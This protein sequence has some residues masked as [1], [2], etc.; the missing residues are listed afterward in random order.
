MEFNCYDVLEV[1]GSRYII[2]EKIKYVEIIPKADQEQSYKAKPSMQKSPGDYWHEYGLEAVEGTDKIWV[3]IEYNDNEWCTVSRTSYHKR[4]GKGFTLHQIGLEK[5]VEV[6]GESGASVGDR[7]GYKE[8]QLPCEGGAGVFFEENWFKGEKMFAEGA[9]VP[10]MNIRLCNDAAAVAIREKKRNKRLK[11][12]IGALAAGLGYG[13]LFTLFLVGSDHDLS[14]H[15]I[16]STFGFP[17]TVK[18]HMSDTSAY[19]TKTDSDSGDVYTSNLDPVSTALDLIDSVQGDIRN[20]GDDLQ[21]GHEVIVFY[22]E[23]SAYIITNTDGQ[24]RVKVCDQSKLT[25]EDQSIINRTVSKGHTLDSYALIIRQR[26]SRGRDSLYNT[27]TA[28]TSS[29]TLNSNVK[30]R[31]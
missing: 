18:E 6:D 5:V 17:Y 21:E 7:A 16:R 22:S 25:Q 12:R 4:P 28:N 11:K 14:W 29:N 3:T 9:R 31:Y 23:D 1:Q 15:G 20:E 13:V 8:Y 19:Y 2:T 24:T 26:D 10:L 27:G 30:L